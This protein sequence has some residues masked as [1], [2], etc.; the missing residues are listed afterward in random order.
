MS[1]LYSDIEKIIEKSK[2][3]ILKLV[4]QDNKVM[5]YSIDQICLDSIPNYR[6]Y[7]SQY[8]SLENAS[9]YFTIN[10]GIN[11]CS[12]ITNILKSENVYTYY[13]EENVLKKCPPLSLKNIK[14][15][16]IYN[17]NKNI[18][19]AY[20]NYFNFIIYFLNKKNEVL[21]S[22]YLKKNKED[23]P[24]ICFYNNMNDYS[25][26]INYGNNKLLDKLGTHWSDFLNGQINNDNFNILIKDYFNKFLV[27][28]ERII[29]PLSTRHNLGL[30][31][32]KNSY[33]YKIIQLNKFKEIFDC[34][35]NCLKNKQNASYLLQNK[36]LNTL[37]Q[38]NIYIESLLTCVNKALNDS[39]KQYNETEKQRQSINNELEKI[40]KETDSIIYKYNNQKNYMY[41]KNW[42]LVI[43]ITFLILLLCL[44]SEDVFKN[45]DNKYLYYKEIVVFQMSTLY[46]N[47]KPVIENGVNHTIIIVKE[48]CIFLSDLFK[49]V[50]YNNDNNYEYL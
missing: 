17:Y 45:L 43:I 20:D 30:D 2:S 33:K 28:D 4:K 7:Y 6:S 42:I 12:H 27:K 10:N 50:Q 47:L 29:E 22:Y 41:I 44:N 21:Y 19:Y 1:F 23:Y 37:K 31:N 8:I 13:K 18:W 24:L 14:I 40:K 11:D 49:G 48:L 32:Y 26:L 15:I 39:K 3:D 16:H 46:N 25:E 5:D 9:D 35:I 36:E 38:D 34:L